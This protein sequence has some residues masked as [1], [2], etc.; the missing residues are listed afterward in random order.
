M[1]DKNN[2][3]ELD[4]LFQS[5]LR[6]N[7]AADN[8]WNVPPIDIFENALAEIEARQPEKKR[9]WP[10]LF[11]V[12]FGFLMLGAITY[13]FYQNQSM[14]VEL[15]KKIE[16]LNQAQKESEQ[17]TIINKNESTSAAIIQDQP[18]LV[19]KSAMLPI[20]AQKGASR[21]TQAAKETTTQRI[22]PIN[23]A[24]KIVNSNL[25][26]ST[27]STSRSNDLLRAAEVATKSIPQ[28][29]SNN[30]ISNVVLSKFKTLNKLPI[31]SIPLTY[32]SRTIQ[33]IYI[34]EETEKAVY[35]D[36]KSNLKFSPY[37]AIGTNFSS[38]NTSYNDLHIEGAVENKYAVGYNIGFGF[39][40]DLTNRFGLEY[41]FTGRSN[42][43]RS[44]YTC[45]VIYD[46]NEEGYNANGDLVYNMDMF[47]TNPLYSAVARVEV[48]VNVDEMD[49]GDVMINKTDSKVVMSVLNTKLGVR[50]KILN[51]TK[52]NLFV[53]G[54][55]GANY[56]YNSKDDLKMQLIHEDKMMMD[57]T[58]PS[59]SKVFDEFFASA[60][61]G[62]QLNYQ[63]NDRIWIG[64][65]NNFEKGFKS[66]FTHPNL[67]AGSSKLKTFNSTIKVGYNF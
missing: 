49:D 51:N 39:S 36:K 58:A 15:D 48:P 22:K 41:S 40:V 12:G 56:I 10:I 28:N 35:S 65:D 7:E 43:S 27:V 34:N 17:L 54:G 67:N 23:K 3:K 19:E 30:T 38:F 25:A 2:N 14:I 24:Q 42:V 18:A 32:T 50:Y 37:L 11:F 64:L 4:K 26:V 60:Y 46:K 57:K 1:L 20:N 63:L 52:F 55:M 6:N 29:E 31:L 53:N 5:K 21:S 45:N 59:G 13:L 44:K 61:L 9:R 8:K 66:L 62:L 33:Q 16:V 47:S